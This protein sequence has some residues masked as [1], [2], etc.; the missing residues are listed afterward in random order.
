MI[1]FTDEFAQILRGIADNIIA[2]YKRQAPVKTGALRDSIRAQVSE[3]G[4]SIIYRQYGVYT[5]YGTYDNRVYGAE[6]PP[7]PFEMPS[8]NPAPGRGG[9]GI[10]PRYW[11]SLYG[12]D[13]IGDM[14][15]EIAEYLQDAI[16]STSQRNVNPL[17]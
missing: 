14:E 16:A 13:I 7:S 2:I 6:Q 5:D 17:S 1:D 12:V 11:T 8:W 10:R 4:I 15:R 9:K 3:K